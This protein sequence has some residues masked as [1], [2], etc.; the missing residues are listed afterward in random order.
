M[1]WEVGT[2]AIH[3]IYRKRTINSV[4]S[5]LVMKVRL[6]QDKSIFQCVCRESVSEEKI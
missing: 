2:E 1:P 6:R 4:S 5:E 3:G